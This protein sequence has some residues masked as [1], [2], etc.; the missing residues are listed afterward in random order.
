MRGLQRDWHK[1][2]NRHMAQGVQTIDYYASVSGFKHLNAG[3]KTAFSFLVLVVCVSLNDVWVSVVVLITMG[4]CNLFGNGVSICNYIRLLKIPITFLLLGSAAIALGI[5]AEPTGEYEVSLHWFYLYLT[6]EG[7]RQAAELFLKAMGAV[8]AM[9]F[10]VLSTPASEIVGVLSK[11]HIPKLVVELM[12]MIY[13][14]IFVLTDMHGS[15]KTAA[16][17]RLGY[18][19]FKTSCRSFGQIAGNLFIL[20]LKKADAYYDAMISRG[21]SGELLFLEEEKKAKPVQMAGMAGYLILLLLVWYI[22]RVV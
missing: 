7:M 17:S 11:A 5:S 15:M 19:D 16:V 13:R 10:M 3:I 9:Y 21:Y 4:I 14:F 18:A 1:G 20:S 8:S 22:R 2:R 6:R 12:H